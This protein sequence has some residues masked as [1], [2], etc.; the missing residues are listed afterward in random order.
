MPVRVLRQPLT[1]F[2]GP[3]HHGP[4]VALPPGIERPLQSHPPLEGPWPESLHD[5]PVTVRQLRPELGFGCVQ[6][7][8]CCGGRIDSIPRAKDTNPIV[9]A[10]PCLAPLGHLLPPS[11]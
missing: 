6:L 5:L 9:N 4:T 1:E 8:I 10:L 2:G 11:S 7:R 3:P